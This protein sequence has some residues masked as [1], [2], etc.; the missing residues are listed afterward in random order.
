MRE[1]IDALRK[2]RDDRNWGKFHTPKDLAISVSIE[3][4]E[5]LELFQW[6]QDSHDTD[7]LDHSK[8]SSEA[9]DVLIYLLFLFD[10]LGLDPEEEVR[11]KM[12]INSVRF[13]VEEAYGKPRLKR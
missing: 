4:A 8:V 9:S 2:F 11:K 5:L 1:I 10:R 13:P 7:A 3:A 6:T 12:A